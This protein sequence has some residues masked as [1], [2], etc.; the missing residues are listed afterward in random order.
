M[1]VTLLGA[2]G[3]SEPHH[4]TDPKKCVFER[5]A[6]DLFLLTVPFSLGD[7]QGIRLWHNNSGNHPAWYANTKIL[8]VHI[9]I[10]ILTP[11]KTVVAK[12]NRQ[13]VKTCDSW[14]HLM[15]DRWPFHKSY[16]I[17][18]KSGTHS[19][20]NIQSNCSRKHLRGYVMKRWFHLA[21]EIISQIPQC[22]SS[23]CCY[24]P[25]FGEY[26]LWLELKRGFGTWVQ[27]P[28]WYLWLAEQWNELLTLVVVLPILP[29]SQ[30]CR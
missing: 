2:D 10:Y 1:T 21:P 15:S 7:L 25:T 11:I 29:F 27:K 24:C 18:S 28:D 20:R 17:Y 30:V 16:I 22:A 13:P 6:L 23:N 4:L 9:K 12:M 3:N 8:K 26:A 14:E 19:F 5:G